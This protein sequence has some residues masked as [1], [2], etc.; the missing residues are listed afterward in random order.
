LSGKQIH[1][2][3]NRVYLYHLKNVLEAEGIDCLIK[4]EQL[5]SIAGGVPVAEAWPQLWV[6][7]R[8]KEDKAREI[9]AQYESSVIH[10]ESW[11]CD[12]CGEEHAP[13]FKDCWNCSQPTLFKD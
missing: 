5:S 8:S 10:G 12:N 13:Q 6:N 11:V 9:I 3:E 4:N 2:A 7:R 1:T